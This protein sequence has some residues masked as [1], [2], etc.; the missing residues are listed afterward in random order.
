MHRSGS[1]EGPRHRTSIEPRKTET[2][3]C[4]FTQ[5]RWRRACCCYP[6]MR[7]IV[8]LLVVMCGGCGLYFGGG[9]AGGGGVC[10]LD[11]V[12]KLPAQE[13]RDPYTGQCEPFSGGGGGTCGQ[14][15]PCPATGV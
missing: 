11:T 2:P 10:N 9:G 3:G 7:R 4:G 15:E 1:N 12:A 8:C 13:L 5:L 14:C 6:A